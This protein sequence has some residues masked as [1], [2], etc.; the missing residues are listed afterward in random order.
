MFDLSG[1]SAIVTGGN[2]GIGLAIASAL[3]S[4]GCSVSIWGRNGE[5]TRHALEQLRERGAQGAQ[6]E[7]CDVT[8]PAAVAA[9]FAST[10]EAFGGRVDGCFVNAGIGGGS[11]VPFVERSYADWR[12]SFAVNLDGAYHVLKVAADHMVDRARAGQPGGR[13]VATSSVASLFGTARNEGY[14]ASKSALNGLVRALAVELA[15]YR[16]TANAILPGYVRSDMTG[17]L[18]GNERFLQAVEGRI[19][20][21]R[22]GD[23][24]EFGGVAVYLMS[25]ASTYHTGDCLVVD[26]GYSAC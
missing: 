11:R 4:A 16:V 8:E 25:D 1:K 7:I 24:A 6:A 2:G 23:P 9:A 19:P 14:G 22:F 20:M 10:L 13:L 3:C 12:E 5:K 18:M 21:R 26:G 15:R 17:E